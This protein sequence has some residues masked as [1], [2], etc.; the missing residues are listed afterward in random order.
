[1]KKQEVR[2]MIERVGI[3]P[4]IRASSAKKRTLPRLR[5]KRRVPIVEITMTFRERWK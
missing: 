4:V 1:M 5:A 2:A 3:V